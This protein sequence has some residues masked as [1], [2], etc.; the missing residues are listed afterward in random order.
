MIRWALLITGTIAGVIAGGFYVHRAP[1]VPSIPKTEPS[2]AV[3][4]LRVP[5]LAGAIELDG[6]TE[7]VG[8]KHVAHTGG[9][10]G[11]D[12]KPARPHSEARFAWGDGKL[13]ILLY[14][15]DENIESAADSFHVEV[16]GQAYDVN[17]VG[18]VASR[19]LAT[20]HDVDGTIDDPTDDDEE[21]V[22][23]M[24]VP[25]ARAESG[26]RVPISIHRCDT[27][28]GSASVCGEWGESKPTVLVLE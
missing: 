22:I 19:A 14:A 7:D 1:P 26:A 15:A 23:E 16:G 3:R 8:W 24:A 11:P 21:W 17:P 5:K 28:K 2:S 9:F 18:V 4:E 20:G 13:W 27:P 12:R 10:L 25:L 6:E